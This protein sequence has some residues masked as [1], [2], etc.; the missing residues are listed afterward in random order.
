M[1]EDFDK[2]PVE[3]LV[4]ALIKRKDEFFL[5]D[6]SGLL[7]SPAF[8]LRM[9]LGAM[10]CVDGIPYRFN[11]QG[12]LE[13][14]AIRRLTGAFP[15]KLVLNG[16]IIAKSE[17]FQKALQRHYKNDL[18]VE[19]LINDSHPLDVTQ[20]RK[21]ESDE[22]WMQDPGKDHNIA[23]VF[24]VQIIGKMPTHT[25]K[26]DP[27]MW[28]TEDAMPP[29]SEFGYT[30]WRLYRKA[31]RDFQLLVNGNAK[32][33]SFRFMRHIPVGR[34]EFNCVCGY[35]SGVDHLLN[36]GNQCIAC[37]KCGKRYIFRQQKNHF[38]FNIRIS[39]DEQFEQECAAGLHK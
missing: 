9:I 24:F 13:L 1:L 4:D 20:Y 5:K 35:Y 19:V 38:H 8:K 16:G 6:N 37:K 21:E 11:A 7:T 31:F 2:V 30:N 33:P 15:G 22:Y 29:E 32:L 23:A 39:E 25:L 10:P 27:V 34:F 36:G 14:M 3:D 17:T 28:F 26:G 18:G 12:D